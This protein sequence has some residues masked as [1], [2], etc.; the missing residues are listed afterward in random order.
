M[1]HTVK[2]LKRGSVNLSFELSR[3]LIFNLNQYALI[4]H[5]YLIVFNICDVFHV[6]YHLYQDCQCHKMKLQY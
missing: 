3:D 6:A 2:Y 5:P 4:T 1:F